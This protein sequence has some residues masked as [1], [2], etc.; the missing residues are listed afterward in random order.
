MTPKKFAAWYNVDVR[1]N[2]SVEKIIPNSKT[3]LVK[4]G[5]KIYEE[6]YDKLLIATGARPSKQK[7]E[8]DDSQKIANLWTMSD[9][10]NILSK[11]SKNV[12]KVAVVG[13]GFVGLETAENLRERGLDV[14]VIQRS[15]HVMPTL[16]FEMAYPLEKEISSLG[17]DL[18]LA[19]TIS[20]YEDTGNSLKIHLDNSEIV[21]ADFAIVGTALRRTRNLPKMPE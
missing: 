7:T 10:D 5:G 3:V 8:G 13:A 21:E 14:V 1:I 4:S 19:R 17:I 18:K 2:S 16:D 20:K 9:M 12:G 6:S 11:L 15:P